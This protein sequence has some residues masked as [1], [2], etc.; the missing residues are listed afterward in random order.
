M[1][2]RSGAEEIVGFFTVRHV[3][4]QGL[5][6]GV[7]EVC[8]PLLT[9]NNFSTAEFHPQYIHPLPLYVARPIKFLPACGGARP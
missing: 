3:I 4:A 6:N 1:R 5:I 7:F 9:G 8:E 2:S